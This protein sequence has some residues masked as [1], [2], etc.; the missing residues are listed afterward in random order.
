MA[1]NLNLGKNASLRDIKRRCTPFFQFLLAFR[2]V[3]VPSAHW[4]QE[5]ASAAACTHIARDKCFH[6]YE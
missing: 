4:F 3:H 2:E 5:L 1:I 6:I